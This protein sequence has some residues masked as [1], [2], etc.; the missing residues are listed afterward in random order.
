MALKYIC[1][2]CG[3]ETD[4]KD[5]CFNCREKY[6]ILKGSGILGA[7]AGYKTT[8]ERPTISNIYTNELGSETQKLIDYVNR[9]GTIHYGRVVA[10]ERIGAR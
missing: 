9:S 6:G 1:K 5:G 3:T 10:R 7:K 8:G 4:H 2:W